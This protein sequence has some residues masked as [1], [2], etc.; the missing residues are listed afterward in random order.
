MAVASTIKLN[1]VH[2][3]CEVQFGVFSPFFR[4]HASAGD[5]LPWLYPNVN[6]LEPYWRLRSALQPY[7]YTAADIAWRTG[8]IISRPLYYE[9]PAGIE[10][11][12]NV[13]QFRGSGA[14]LQYAFG[15]AFVV[16]AVTVPGTPA[17]VDVFV[18]PGRWLPV[19][20][21]AA[22]PG[23]AIVG[24]AWL[25]RRPYAAPEYPVLARAG[26]VVPMKRLEDARVVSP[27][28]VV[29]TVFW[30]A[31]DS[32]TG[33]LVEDDGES[34]DYQSGIFSKV[35]FV[36]T[37]VPEAKT[38]KLD[39]TPSMAPKHKAPE[40]R[41]YDVRFRGASAAP[42]SVTV[43]G[44]EAGVDWRQTDGG[45]VGDDDAFAHA[46]HVVVPVLFVSS[47]WVAAADSVSIVVQW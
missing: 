24:P 11:V 26:A 18:P 13:S 1:G 36:H 47:G 38:T 44:V 29:V 8:I 46:A 9:W 41:M 17:A 3:P 28:V 6:E 21:A 19:L 2:P 10:A 31:A 37:A 40:V 22:Q 34:L 35:A 32:G 20:E 12:Y 33:L 14:S 27:A 23:T 30:S 45:L 7:I 5:V 4:P 39:V 42:R 25:P 16:A 43:N 15:D